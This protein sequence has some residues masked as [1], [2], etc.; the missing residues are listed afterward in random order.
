MESPVEV[1]FDVQDLK[2]LYNPNQKRQELA[3]KKASRSLEW[4][5]S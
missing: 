5:T 1:E 3:K 4:R 2:K